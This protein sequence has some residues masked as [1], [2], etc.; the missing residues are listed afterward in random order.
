MFSWVCT[1][2]P[3]LP[4]NTTARINVGDVETCENFTFLHGQLCVTYCDNSVL[5]AQGVGWLYLPKTK[6]K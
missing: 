2:S 3:T 6:D 5:M 1:N 4:N